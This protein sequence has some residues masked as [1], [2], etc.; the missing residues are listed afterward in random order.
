MFAARRTDPDQQIQFTGVVQTVQWINP[1]V[2][3][4]VE[5]REPNGNRVGYTIQGANPN[6]LVSMGITPKLIRAGD[7]VTVEGLRSRENLLIVGFATITT[8]N[9]L[10]IFL[11]NSNFP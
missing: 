3:V 11:G 6:G 5:V 7:T 8:S 1:H 10:K 2:V 4:G 9:G